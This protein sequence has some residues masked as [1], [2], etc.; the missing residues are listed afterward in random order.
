ML[1]SVRISVIIIY[2]WVI[3]YI[4]EQRLN[5][6]IFYLRKKGFSFAQIKLKRFRIANKKI[7][8]HLGKDMLTW[9]FFE[10]LFANAFM[11]GY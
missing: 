7:R 2:Y 6:A 1:Q 5:K 9:R 8:E 4:L 3:I 11:T 10:N